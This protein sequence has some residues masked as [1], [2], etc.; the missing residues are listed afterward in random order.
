MYAV[1]VKDPAVNP[2]AAAQESCAFAA[3]PS[4]PKLPGNFQQQAVA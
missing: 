1:I 4:K 2:V 3:E